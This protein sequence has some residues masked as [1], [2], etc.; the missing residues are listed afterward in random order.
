MNIRA[1]LILDSLNWAAWDEVLFELNANAMF[2]FHNIHLVTGPFSSAAKTTS[3]SPFC[4]VDAVVPVAGFGC[5][6]QFVVRKP[7][8]N[9]AY[10]RAYSTK[11][12]K[13]RRMP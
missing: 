10:T 8:Q 3:L 1:H 5:P 6:R 4:A 2:I 13:R 7:V 9:Y 11:F 12:R